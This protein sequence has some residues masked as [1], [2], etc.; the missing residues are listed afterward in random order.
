[1]IFFA[2]NRVQIFFFLQETH[3]RIEADN[4]VTSQWWF[5]VVLQWGLT[6]VLQWGL[7]V[8]SQWGLTVVLQLGFTVVSQ[9]RLTVYTGDLQLCQNG[10]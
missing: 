7:T 6:V 3:W 5:T 1:M 8:V 4:L 9:Q 2:N 10:D